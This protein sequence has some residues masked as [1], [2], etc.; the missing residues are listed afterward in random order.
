[1]K[2]D[3]KKF[4]KGTYHHGKNQLIRFI[5]WMLN[6]CFLA[7]S[8]PYPSSMKTILL[9]I[10]GAKIGRNVVIKP[11]VNIK[12]P[13]Y[14]TVRDASW[15]GEY[16]WIDNLVPVFIGSNVCI[17]QGAYLCT[18]N[19]D[20]KKASFDLMAQSIV[21]EDGVWIGAFTK[22][23]PGVHAGE[24]SVLTMGSIITQSMVSFGIYQGNPA[25]YTKKREIHP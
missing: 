25:V 2:T 9:R 14:L 19:H 20:Y 18:G 15:I 3:L 17:S 13:W 5:W 4:N 8:F 1:M 7:S 21:I 6:R 22:V 11:R 23:G 16:V 12:H 10:F 24:H